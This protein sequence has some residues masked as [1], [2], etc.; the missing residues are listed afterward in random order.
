M[1]VST[2]RL[3]QMV[4]KEARQLLRD[5]RTRMVMFVSPIIQLLLF[6]YAVNTDIRNTATFV[7]DHDRT[8]ESRRLM[9]AFTASGYFTVTGQSDRPGDLVKVL[10]HG[11]AVLGIEIPAG[12]ARDLGV[13]RATV[14][15]LVD[16]TDSNTG[17]VALGYA[18]RIVQ[19][20]GATVGM[21]Q[22]PSGAGNGRRMPLGGVELR[23]RV[24][25]NPSLESRTYNV[26]GVIGMLLMLMTL[27]LTALAVVREREIGTLE[28]LMVSP[29]TPTELMLG[30][31]IPVALVALVD[32]FL[33]TAVAML[34]FDIPLRGSVPALL[35]AAGLYI[36][37][38]LSLGLFVS[39][40]SATQQEAFMTMFLFFLPAIILSGFLY[41]VSSMP[42]FFQWL[43]LFNPIRH[44]LD[45]VRGIFLKGASLTELWSHYLALLIMSSGLLTL[46][47]LRFR[48]AVG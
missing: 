37:A 38:G 19:G 25:Y 44:F 33:V 47:V 21:G 40:I 18:G 15:L 1:A 27:L 4:T 9:E 16:G 23:T 32:L 14:Q 42:R 45:V 13:G 43:T 17:I 39:T 5:P 22:G 6:G 30:K 24:W 36:L 7:V 31:T 12:F 10:D 48:K 35:I 8:M 3:R 2:L 26:P 11:D 41:P 46:A 20:F 28:Q 34:W 29:L